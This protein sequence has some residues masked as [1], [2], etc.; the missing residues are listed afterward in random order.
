MIYTARTVDMILYNR[1]ASTFAVADIAERLHDDIW[2]MVDDLMIAAA[3][4][5]ARKERHAR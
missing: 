1:P 5:L 4:L 2:W 3:R